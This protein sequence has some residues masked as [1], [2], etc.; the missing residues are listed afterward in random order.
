MNSAAMETNIANTFLI[1]YWIFA[2]VF[3]LVK[4]KRKP[5]RLFGV[6]RSSVLIVLLGV[7]VFFLWRIHRIRYFDPDLVRMEAIARI[8]KAGGANGILTEAHAILSE[9]P[10]EGMHV[11]TAAELANY[12]MLR[13][14]GDVESISSTGTF[15]FNQ[16]FIQVKVNSN[17]D[18]FLIILLDNNMPF[19]DM[20]GMRTVQIDRFI[21]AGK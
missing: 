11:F 8:N 7:A 16:R 4:R 2:I 13:S 19:R 3:L 6:S 10:G 20:S 9:H 17:L 15:T 21:Y 12:P 18:H 14:L 1:L 5:F